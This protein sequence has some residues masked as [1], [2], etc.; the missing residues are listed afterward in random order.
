MKIGLDEVEYKKG[1]FKI[2]IIKYLLIICLGIIDIYIAELTKIEF[3]KV[4]EG[5][6]I[7][8][9]LYCL[10]G[11]AILLKFMP[12][13]TMEFKGDSL[14]YAIDCTDMT[15]NPFLHYKIY[16]YY[17]VTSISESK[18]YYYITGEMDITNIYQIIKKS[19]TVKHRKGTF[20]IPKCFGEA[21]SF[22]AELAKL[23]T[24]KRTGSDTRNYQ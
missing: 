23:I 5:L 8:I 16:R 6:Y 24:A 7:I 3:F 21:N 11:I 17:N 20:K 14:E 18:Y 15:F 4:I 9:F 22:K 13:A 10:T 2:K 1:Y 12:K 19:P